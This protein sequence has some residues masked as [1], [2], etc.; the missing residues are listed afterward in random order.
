MYTKYIRWRKLQ[1]VGH[2]KRRK[3]GNV[4]KKAMEG[5]TKGE[6]PAGRPRGGWLD[7]VDRDA[8][9]MLKCRNWKRSVEDKDC[10]RRRIGETKAQ[11]GRPLEEEELRA[12]SPKLSQRASGCHIYFLTSPFPI[13][14]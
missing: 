9:R 14:R 5:Y 1:W 10:W 3:D 8:K 6:K 12:I 11:F 4:P 2:V 7:A 13:S